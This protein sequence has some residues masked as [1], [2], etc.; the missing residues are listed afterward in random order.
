MALLSCTHTHKKWTFRTAN[1]ASNLLGPFYTNKCICLP[2]HHSPFRLKLSAPC[3]AAADNL[4]L[5]ATL[6]SLIMKK[7]W[8]KK[9][10]IIIWLDNSCKHS[11]IAAQW[12]SHSSCI[13]A[14]LRPMSVAQMGYFTLQH[15]LY[16]G[17]LSHPYVNLPWICTYL[18]FS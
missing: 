9:Y 13:I 1:K 12:C 8:K 10:C 4:H 14:R 5:K 3:P 11:H 6:Q 7:S 15:D 16:K 18:N 17:N 2:L